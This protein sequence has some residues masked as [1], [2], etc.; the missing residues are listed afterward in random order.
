LSEEH[1]GWTIARTWLGLLDQRLGSEDCDDGVAYRLMTLRA[2]DL[3]HNVAQTI[4]QW[5]TEALTSYLLHICKIANARPQSTRL[6]RLSSVVLGA[7][8]LSLG[9]V[10]A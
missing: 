9:M 4:E 7:T 3:R 6:R 5:S 8:L 2:Q 1:P 10:T